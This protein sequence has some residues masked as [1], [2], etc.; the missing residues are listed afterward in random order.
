MLGTIILAMIVLSVIIVPLIY[1]SRMAIFLT[2]LNINYIGDGLR[3][4]LDP[5]S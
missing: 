1:T 5:R 2:V 3:D 4:A